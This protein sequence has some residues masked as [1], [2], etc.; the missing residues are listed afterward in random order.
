MVKS[1]IPNSSLNTPA[2]DDRLSLPS[3]LFS[4]GFV[5]AI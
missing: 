3:V 5:A 4:H 2:F 1:H